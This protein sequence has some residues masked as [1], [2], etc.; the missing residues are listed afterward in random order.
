M[1]IKKINDIVVH[2]IRDANKIQLPV[3]GKDLLEVCYSNIFCLAKKKSGKTTVIYRLMRQTISRDTKVFIF[4]STVHKD[5]AYKKLMD[6]LDSRS[7]YFE[8]YND[9][10]EDGENIVENILN[11]MKKQGSDEAEDEDAKVEQKPKKTLNTLMFG[12]DEEKEKKK[13]KNKYVVPDY[14]FIFDD[15]GQTLRNPSI[16]QLLKTN[17]HYKARIIISSQ[18]LHDLQP[19]SMQQLDYMFIFK[20]QTDEKLMTIHTQIDLSLDIDQ[21]MKMYKIATEKM[22]NFLYIDIRNEQYR[23]NFNTQLIP[24]NED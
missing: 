16:S 4:C 14:V 1:K 9:I 13:R 8:S 22:Y 17:R 10:F 21:F 7:I 24:D 2:P 5:P 20:G 11:E 19:A 6:W 3:K 15:L 12:G 18:Y 23:R